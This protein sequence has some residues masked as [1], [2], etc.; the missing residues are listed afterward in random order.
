[1]SEVLQQML[2][3]AGDLA[4]DG[5]TKRRYDV[6]VSLSVQ[7][8]TDDGTKE[9]FRNTTDFA[10]MN[11]HDVCLVEASYLELLNGMTCLGFAMWHGAK[12]K[13]AGR[14]QPEG[15]AVGAV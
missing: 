9:F 4:S 8:H 15:L 2:A 6:R 3:R 5:L 13:E 1:M 12:Q 10:A 14:P 7:E 11:Y